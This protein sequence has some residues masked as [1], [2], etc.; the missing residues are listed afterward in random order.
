[1][2]NL[3]TILVVATAA[4]SSAQVT[5]SGNAYLFRMKYAQG[6]VLK[7]SVLSTIGG[8]SQNGQ[9]MKFTLPM[10]W[11]VVSVAK[12]VST[13]DTT[14][15]PV[16]MGG[17]QPMMQATKNRIQLDNRGRLVGQ[18]GT[19]QQ[20]TPALPE[21]PIRVGQSWSSTAPINLPTQGESKISATYTFKGVKVV[22][23]KPMAELA[24]KT[25]GQAVGSGTMLLMMKDG[26]LFRSQLKM[27]LQ[28]TSA[29][30]APATYKVTAQISRQ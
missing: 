24:V 22:E 19:G 20:V 23:G 10:I 1:M 18:P 3:F 12:G 11:K 30:G 16:S 28:M 8:M 15:G 21:K 14:V 9:P 29:N 25:S 17:N 6:N 27:D 7:Y 13:I 2:K 5:K 4:L 26:T